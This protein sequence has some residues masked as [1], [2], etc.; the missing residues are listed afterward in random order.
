[1]P[2]AHPS[3]KIIRYES[4]FRVIPG[5][6]LVA[7]LL[8]TIAILALFLVSYSSFITMSLHETV[9]GKAMVS[10]VWSLENYR[11]FFSDSM[12]FSFLFDT[13]YRSA[14]ITLLSLM[15][16]Y[17][18]AYCLARSSSKILR[19]IMMLAMI[20]PLLSGGITMAYSWMVLLGNVGLVN[21]SLRALGIIEKPIRFLYNWLGVIIALVHYCLPYTAL[22]L[23]GPIRNVPR[24]LEEAGV[25]LGAS[26]PTIFFRIVLP[27]TASGIIEATSLTYSIALSSFLFPMVLGG[28]KVKMMANIIY[29]V[30]I[31]ASDFPFAGTLATALLF[32]SIL[33][34]LAMTFLQR[35]VRRSHE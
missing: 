35:T 6:T 5:R 15:I 24:T 19:H 2:K 32:V 10:E 21:S 1:M 9:P 3:K 13:L 29:E 27:L 7:I 14:E 18:L 25:N 20:I 16:A 23:I 28:G 26:K 11:R 33:T 8:P 12:Y 17:P 31:I 4:D 30:T 22:S 34:V